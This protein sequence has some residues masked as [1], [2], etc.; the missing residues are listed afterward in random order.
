MSPGGENRMIKR[1]E[2]HSCEEN[3]NVNRPTKRDQCGSVSFLGNGSFV[4]RLVDSK[5]FNKAVEYVLH[6]EAMFSAIT[7]LGLGITLKPLLTMAMPGA[8]KKDKTAIAAKNI[9]SAVISY[10]LASIIMKP[11]NT[12]VIKLTKN[13]A[14]YIKRRELCR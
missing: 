5:K 1:D 4:K 6:N 13:P 7:T 11:I 9:T 2:L 14:K 12:G 8:G 3:N 10:V